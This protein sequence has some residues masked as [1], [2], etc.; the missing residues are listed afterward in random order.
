MS[1]P[2]SVRRRAMVLGLLLL[3]FGGLLTCLGQLQPAG[4]ASQVVVLEIAEGESFSEVAQRLRA[5]R[6]IKSVWAFVWMGRLRGLDR[7]IIP[8]EYEFHGGM[9]P[10]RILRKLSRGEVRHY[11]VTIPEGFSAKQIADAL[12]EKQ[13]ADRA[14]YLRFTRDPALIHRLGLSVNDL[15]GYLFPDTYLLTR[16]MRPEVI[17]QT[18]VSRFWQIVTEDDRARAKALGFSL[19]Q[20]VTLASVIEKEAARSDERALISGVF[21]NRL[22]HNIPLQSDPTVIYVLHEFDGDLRKKDLAIDS[23]YNTYRVPG[24]PPGPIA[25]PGKAS[26]HAALYPASTEYLYFVSRNDGSHEFSATLAD[27]QRAVQKYQM[28]QRRRSS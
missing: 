25:N 18:M 9:S 20:V 26:I 10:V 23:P 5:H 4:Q 27:H 11:T 16:H 3:V 2:A 15:E 8:G 24:L 6:M 1:H 22:R 19:H 13:L 12:H 28:R 21:H 7:K 17:I 14:E